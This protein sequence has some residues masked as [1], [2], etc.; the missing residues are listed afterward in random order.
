MR[1][2][3]ETCFPVS[4]SDSGQWSGNGCD[5]S[6]TRLSIGGVEQ[7]EGNPGR[8]K[9]LGTNVGTCKPVDADGHVDRHILGE[10]TADTAGGCVSCTLNFGAHPASLPGTTSFEL[11]MRLW[12]VPTSGTVFGDS[13]SESL[14]GISCAVCAI[15]ASLLGWTADLQ[16]MRISPVWVD[17]DVGSFVGEFCPSTSCASF[18]ELIR[19]SQGE[20][21]CV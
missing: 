8:C 17:L 13:S 9:S 20:L 19:D 6:A 14:M 15:L 11:S 18:E 2:I 1:M 12:G 10:P 21:T 16:S 5:G 7:M 4:P 3:P